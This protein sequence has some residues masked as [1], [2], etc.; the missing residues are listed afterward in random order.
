MP[1]ISKPE[2]FLS[3]RQTL[4]SRCPCCNAF[5]NWRHHPN[6]DGRMFGSCCSLAFV[7]TPTG[8]QPLEF[9]IL[10]YKANRQNL[11]VLP[12]PHPEEPCFGDCEEDEQGL[13]E[14][15]D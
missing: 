7:V 15:E 8:D 6:S 1:R 10:A 5:I 11:V 2:L 4:L 3:A 14:D 12:S 13:D 9:R